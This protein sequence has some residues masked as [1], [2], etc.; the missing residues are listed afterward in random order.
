MSNPAHA[1]SQINARVARLPVKQRRDFWEWLAKDACAQID[2]LEIEQKPK[3]DPAAAAVL[4]I[5]LFEPTENE[6]REFFAAD[7][8]HMWTTGSAMGRDMWERCI[9]PSL[10]FGQNREDKTRDLVARLLFEQPSTS[11]SSSAQAMPPPLPPLRIQPLPPLVNNVKVI[12]G[13]CTKG[14]CQLCGSTHPLACVIKIQDE[15]LHCGTQC[16]ERFEACAKLLRWVAI[17]RNRNIGDDRN[18]LRLAAHVCGRLQ[19]RIVST[20]GLDGQATQAEKNGVFADVVADEQRAIATAENVGSDVESN[21]GDNGSN[22]EDED[23]DDDSFIAD[24]GT[25]TIYSGSSK[26]EEEEEY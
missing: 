23:E 6:V 8:S 10:G 13:P 19:K 16:A 12:R 22:A 18:E 24:E 15:Q 5:R 26:E 11:S 20:L 9:V 14:I 2:R 1:I 4:P 3:I 21:D 17:T 25:A 7:S